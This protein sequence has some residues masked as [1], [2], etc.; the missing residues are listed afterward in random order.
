MPLS[1]AQKKGVAVGVGLLALLALAGAANASDDTDDTDD[2]DD[3]PPLPCPPG[4]VELIQP[5]GQ[6][7]CVRGPDLPDPNDDDPLPPKPN[8]CN[9][10]GCGNPFD[11]T[12]PSPG[13]IA[14]RLSTLGYP[15]NF[16]AIANNGSLIAVEPA[17]GIVRDFQRDSN[18][19]HDDPPAPA[20]SPLAF[21]PIAAAAR[22]ADDGLAG[23]NTIAAITRAITA[24]NN[25][26][27]TW[28]AAVELS[29]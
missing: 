21:A 3:V 13:V 16:V 19:V 4:F 22:L 12:H 6:R 25:S 18:L 11:N 15:I 2:D 20:S 1:S 26:G 24:Q 17:R 9:Y 14:Q 5:N 27:M 7:T 28:L 29:A 23:N 8:V 10:S